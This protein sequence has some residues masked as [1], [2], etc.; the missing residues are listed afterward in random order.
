MVVIVPLIQDVVR[1]IFTELILIIVGL[2]LSILA[3]QLDSLGCILLS[4]GYFINLISYYRWIYTLTQSK[5]CRVVCHHHNRWCRNVTDVVRMIGAEVLIYPVLICSIFK[6]VTGMGY[7]GKTHG[8]RLGFALFVLYC[9]SFMLQVYIARI[10]VV[11]GMMKSLLRPR[12]GGNATAKA[13]ALHY[14]AYFFIHVV[15]HSL[16]LAQILMIVS[17]GGRIYY[18]NGHFYEPGNTDMSIASVGICDSCWLHCTHFG[19][20]HILYSHLL[21]DPGVPNCSG[22]ESKSRLWD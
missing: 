20:L 6:T 16:M 13:L 3:L 21:L 10:I 7:D 1:G 22:K 8:D 9:I 15:L 11:A 19:L 12:Y 18:E 2:V 4:G 14:V 17:I 5:S